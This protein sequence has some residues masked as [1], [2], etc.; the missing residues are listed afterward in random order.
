M[1]LLKQLASYFISSF[2]LLTVMLINTSYRPIVAT[3]SATLLS[4]QPQHIKSK[5]LMVHLTRSG[6]VKFELSCSL[7]ISK[8]P[9]PTSW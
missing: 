8:I 7:H 6:L 5:M 1:L 4:W 3:R 2:S 9:N